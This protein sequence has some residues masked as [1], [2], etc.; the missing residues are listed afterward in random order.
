MTDLETT[1]AL[2]SFVQSLRDDPFYSSAIDRGQALSA[3]D[4]YAWLMAKQELAGAIRLL[5][6]LNPGCSA[7]AGIVV[8][9]IFEMKS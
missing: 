5:E 9:A 6:V 2:T 3:E 1:I 4:K 8:P 7:R